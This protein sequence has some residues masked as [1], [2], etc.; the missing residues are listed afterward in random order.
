MHTIAH[1]PTIVPSSSPFPS[2]PASLGVTT[3]GPFS[4]SGNV[5]DIG[6]T[7]SI[8]GPAPCTSP[9]V[10]SAPEGQ[11]ISSFHNIGTRS[12]GGRNQKEAILVSTATQ[13]QVSP[14]LKP[15]YFPDLP[16]QVPPDPTVMWVQWMGAN[17]PIVKCNLFSKGEKIWRFGMLDVTIIAP[18]EWPA[19]WE[20]EPVPR[21]I[22]GIGGVATLRRSKKNIVIRGPEGKMATVRPFVMRAPITLWGW[23]VLA[24]WGA[25]LQISCWD[26]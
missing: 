24:Q 15:F 17:K 21:L 26:F 4:S 19:D 16:Q 23:D 6:N 14:L 22:S 11:P 7:P 25:S 12:G 8:P 3:V 10:S 9:W 1:V 18:S 13:Y 5:P 20:L 2:S